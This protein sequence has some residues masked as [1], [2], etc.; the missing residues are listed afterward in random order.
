MLLSE[1]E[2]DALLLSFKVASVAVLCALP[3]A[4]FTSQIFAHAN[5]RGQSIVD[6]F[7]HLPL[8]LPPVLMGYILLVTL[9][10]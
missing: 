2:L 6:G 3:R 10:T 5:F 4:I 7:V 9:G 8:M 1:A